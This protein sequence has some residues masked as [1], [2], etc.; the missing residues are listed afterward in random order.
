MKKSQILAALALAFALG[1]AVI[2]TAS[3]YAQFVDNNNVLDADLTAKVQKEVDTAKLSCGFHMDN[4]AQ[5]LYYNLY[6]DLAD[7]LDNTAVDV[8]NAKITAFS[9]AGNLKDSYYATIQAF[10]TAASLDARHLPA[11]VPETLPD[12][13]TN[14]DDAVAFIGTE[15][16]GVISKIS[17]A[18]TVTGVVATAYNNAVDSLKANLSAAKAIVTAAENT[19]ATA[20][21]GYMNAINN[22]YYGLTYDQAV[23]AANALNYSENGT[24]SVARVR[25]LRIAV[26]NAQG[27]IN[28]GTQNYSATRAE[29]A[30]AAIKKALNGGTVTDEDVNQ[31]PDMKPT[32]GNKAPDT[33]ILSNEDGGASTTVAMVAGV[34]TALTA[35]GAGVV[36]YRNARRSSRK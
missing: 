15:K 19:A 9:G 36:A 3:T 28:D 8:D 22:V 6:S 7:A 1:V 2:P 29:Q 12:T 25:N 30:I 11:G 13:I 21:M 17:A 26:N 18:S 16:S 27:M 23:K 35:A 31:K 10:M 33:G 20:L 4:N 32:E 34:A 5:V 14:Y 24:C